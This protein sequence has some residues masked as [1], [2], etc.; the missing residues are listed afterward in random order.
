MQFSFFQL[1][2]I[3]ILMHGSKKNDIQLQREDCKFLIGTSVKESSLYLSLKISLNMEINHHKQQLLRFLYHQNSKPR[4]KRTCSSTNYS[5]T[6]FKFLIETETAMNETKPVKTKK[7]V[8]ISFWI[9]INSILWNLQTI[10]NLNQDVEH[11]FLNFIM[12]Q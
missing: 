1:Q 12:L 2:N 4:I 6:T 10:R 7:N 9:K 5:W 11:I 3:K 8:W